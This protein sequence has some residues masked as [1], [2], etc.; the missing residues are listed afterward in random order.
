MADWNL[1]VGLGNPGA[2]YENTRHNIGW[3]AVEAYARKYGLSFDRQEHK[4]LVAAGTIL[5]KRVLLAKPLTFMNLSGESVQP[6]MRFYKIKPPSLLVV[7]DDLDT[8][9]GTL[10]MRISGSSGGQNGLR[11]IIE[12][13]GTPNVNRLRLGISRPPGRMSPSDY[14]LMPFRGDDEITVIETIDRAIKAI[15]TWLTD[16]VELA[17]S[18][19]NGP[20]T[21]IRQ[22]QNETK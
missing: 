4:A 1:I 19:H 12:R 14:V 22:S 6:L 2:K 8:P 11:S 17:M 9:L 13:L 10:R 5:G 7:C 16:G 20:P 18:R 15:D 3:R 21:P